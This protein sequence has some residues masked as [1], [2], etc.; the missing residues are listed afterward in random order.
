MWMLPIIAYANNTPADVKAAN[1]ADVMTA[2]ESA[3][4]SLA[5]KAGAGVE[6]ALAA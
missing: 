2:A 1:A 5:V 3:A 4:W 6:L